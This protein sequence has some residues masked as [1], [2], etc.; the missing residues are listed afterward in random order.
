M[1]RAPRTVRPR[2]EELESR[3]NPYVLSGGSWVYPQLITI[4][5]VPD[6][7]ILG[8]NGQGQAITSTLFNNFSYLGSATTWENQIL[9]GAQVSAQQTNINFSVVSDNGAPIGG[10]S[11][12]QGDPNYGDIRIGGYQEGSGSG[13][14]L[15]YTYMPPQLNNYSIAGDVT[16]NTSQA[17]NI[18][19]TYD[20]FTV[21]AH[22]MGHALGL[23]ESL[24]S[25]AIMYSTYTNTFTSLN[26][27]DISGI[28]AI[29]S[30]GS[31]RSP[32]IYDAIA[33]NGSFATATPVIVSP[34][35]DTV[36]LY[37][38]ITTVADNDY[39]E[40]TAPLLSAST[41]TISVQSE[42]LSL[43]SPKVYV[44]NSAHTQLT[45]KS[46]LDDYGTTLTVTTSIT[47]LATYYI[48]VIGADTTA[49][50]TGAYALTIN[51]GTGSSPAV[52]IPDTE[53]PNGS[54]LQSTGGELDS[55][56]PA[57]LYGYQP[58]SLVKVDTGTGQEALAMGLTGFNAGPMQTL[59]IAPNMTAADLAFQG[60]VFQLSQLNEASRAAANWLGLGGG[61]ALADRVFE[62]GSVTDADG[63]EVA[64]PL[65]WYADPGE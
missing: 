64:L 55:I 54:P 45:F 9:K 51:T 1:R 35:S 46:G 40:F 48:K 39:Y 60:N 34:L 37:A 43:L 17:F 31:G 62:D 19:S 44:Y 41:A 59:V 57:L 36:Q 4:S 26:S 50:S 56:A 27:D 8:Y 23:E 49:F 16:F 29:Y 15:A 18:G 10:G 32:D 6:G 42:G 25:S 7:T 21:A 22:E 63:Q 2:L 12:E 52:T 3:I 14:P 53:T 5:F 61:A 30:G 24:N 33:S 28:Q 13:F 65:S 58:P 38:D 47:P 20:L 11:Y